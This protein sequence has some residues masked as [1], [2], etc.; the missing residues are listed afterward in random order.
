MK[1]EYVKPIL[2]GEKFGANEYI[3]VC[4]SLYCEVAGDNCKFTRNTYFN[5]DVRWDNKTVQA[6]G[7]LHGQPCADGSSWNEETNTFFENGKNSPVSGVNIGSPVQDENDEWYATWYS[8][9]INGTGTYRHY[10]YAKLDMPNK[11]NHS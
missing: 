8:E 11:P 7:Q 1:K 5:R 10:G 4:Y 6:D 2:I 9:D 3:A